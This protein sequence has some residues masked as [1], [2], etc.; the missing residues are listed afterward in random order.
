MKKKYIQME[1]E[2]TQAL[3]NA[4]FK[5]R[6]DNGFLVLAHVSGVWNVEFTGVFRFFYFCFCQRVYKHPNS[7]AI[8]LQT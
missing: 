7:L 6:L 3:P 5:V 1:G 4:M 8:F 2:I